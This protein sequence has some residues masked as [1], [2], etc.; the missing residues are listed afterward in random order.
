MDLL[1]KEK[2]YGSRM[3]YHRNILL[4]AENQSEGGE[5]ETKGL[6]MWGGRGETETESL[7]LWLVVLELLANGWWL[8]EAQSLI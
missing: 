4:S 8:C 2:L 6:I 5:A 7:I 1:E 3:G